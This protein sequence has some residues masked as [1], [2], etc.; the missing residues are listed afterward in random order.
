M[1]PKKQTIKK[2]IKK[3]KKKKKKIISK[4]EKK[5]RNQRKY[6]IEKRNNVRKRL[7]KAVEK[8]EKLIPE[9]KGKNLIYNIPQS[10]IKDLK[11]KR[12]KYSA[13]KQT[14]INQYYQYIYKI[15]NIVDD[16]E[17][18]LIKRFNFKQRG[19]ITA[20]PRKKGE[21]IFE[22]GFI[23]NIDENVPTVIFLNDLVQKVENYDKKLQAPEILDAVKEEKSKMDSEHFMFIIGK[24][25]DNFRIY[26]EN[27]NTKPKKLKKLRKN[28]AK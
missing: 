14:I 17:L 8:L 21:L 16:L 12:K 2:P 11:L 3:A 7:N 25:E 27:L 5:L 24:P 19:A 10:I 28:Y 23:W 4:T 20:K 26:V 13:S 9:K 18:K 15:N 6:Q 22:L 1:A